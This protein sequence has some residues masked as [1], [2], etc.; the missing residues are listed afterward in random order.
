MPVLDELTHGAAGFVAGGGLVA[1][2]A[3]LR[4]IARDRSTAQ[5][6]QTRLEMKHE[7]SESER[8]WKRLDELTADMRESNRKCEERN[9]ECEQR[10]KELERALA[11]TNIELAQAKIAIASVQRKMTPPSGTPKA[12]L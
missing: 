4:A 10:S 3:Q 12:V 9:A 7:E 11:L 5:A 1:L 6:A 8:L 2:V